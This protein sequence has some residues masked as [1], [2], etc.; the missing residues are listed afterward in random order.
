MTADHP[1]GHA[2]RRRRRRHA[3]D[4]GSSLVYG[5]ALVVVALTLGPVLLRRP[6]RLP[7]QRPAGR[8]PVG[9]PDPWVLTNYVERADAPTL[10]AARAQLHGRSRSS[11]PFVV[12][13]G[14]MAAYPLARYRF[15]GRE[16]LYTFFTLGLLFPLTVAIIPLFLLHP[17]PEPDGQPARGWRC[18]RRRSRCR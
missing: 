16:P 5:V 1:A 3:V 11:R 15:R 9:L 17:G 4:R 14:V 12:V 13:F 18:R 6:R 2:G 8:R 7:H 10:L